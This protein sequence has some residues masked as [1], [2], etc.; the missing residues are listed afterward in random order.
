MFL[1]SCFITVLPCDF[2]G[3][4]AWLDHPFLV[5]APRMV[6]HSGCPISYYYKQG[7]HKHPAPVPLM[8]SSEQ[9]SRC[10]H[11]DIERSICLFS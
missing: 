3:S 2:V 11:S 9:I 1:G 5:G 6:C 4:I 10:F 8:R 7:S